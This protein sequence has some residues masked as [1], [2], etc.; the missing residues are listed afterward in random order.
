[1]G[2]NGS[3]SDAQI[4]NRSKLRRK[5]EN[6]TLGLPPPEPR[7]PGGWANLQYF[8]LLDDSIVLMPWLVKYYCRRQLTR[9]ESS[10]L[11]DIQEKESGRECL[12]DSSG[13]VQGATDHHGT[14]AKSNRHCVNMSGTT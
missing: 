11:Q 13:K 5:I 4:F 2:A 10:Q 3:S 14:E 12:W 9:E 7:G 1:M 8:L 6:K